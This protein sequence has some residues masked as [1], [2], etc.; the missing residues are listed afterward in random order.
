METNQP[1]TIRFGL[2]ILHDYSLDR[3]LDP[4]IHQKYILFYDYRILK[5]LADVLLQLSYMQ[6]QNEILRTFLIA[7]PDGESVINAFMVSTNSSIR[8][9][10]YIHWM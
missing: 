2:I 4:F 1:I 6:N 5:Q 8:V 3:I 7:D 9:K 10:E